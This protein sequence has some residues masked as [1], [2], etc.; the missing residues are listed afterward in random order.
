MHLTWILHLN[1]LFGLLPFNVCRFI[2]NDEKQPSMILSIVYTY[3]LNALYAIALPITPT[4]SLVSCLC[5][6][7]FSH[8][9][10][11]LATG[12]ATTSAVSPPSHYCS[13]GTPLPSCPHPYPNPR[14]CCFLSPEHTA[15]SAQGREGSWSYLIHPQSEPKTKIEKRGSK[16]DK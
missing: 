13:T 8:P 6:P 12:H 5:G 16:L 3:L 11:G 9:A 1:I 14:L 15:A 2:S 7:H 4:A 10:S